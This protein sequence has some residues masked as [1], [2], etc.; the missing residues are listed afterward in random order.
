MNARELEGEQRNRRNKKLL[1]QS[2][3]AL[4]WRPQAFPVFIFSVAAASSPWLLVFSFGFDLLCFCLLS[5]AV[6]PLLLFPLTCVLSFHCFSHTSFLHIF[7]VFSILCVTPVKARL[8]E[9]VML[10]VPIYQSRC[11]AAGWGLNFTSAY[12][13]STRFFRAYGS[14]VCN[15]PMS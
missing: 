7:G 9:R 15:N 10:L 14:S 13:K 6:A 4:Y 11:L 1:L 8:E 3:I 2:S 12:S 5:W